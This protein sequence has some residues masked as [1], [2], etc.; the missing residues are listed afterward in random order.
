M[1]GVMAG[2]DGRAPLFVPGV[3]VVITPGKPG[4]SLLK[5]AG[6]L[7]ACLLSVLFVGLSWI[8][9]GLAQLF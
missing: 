6:Y 7:V 8:G 2:G 5:K 3:C 9:S 4:G 1:A